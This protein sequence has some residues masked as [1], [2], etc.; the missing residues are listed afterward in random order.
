VLD[1]ISILALLISVASAVFVGMREGMKLMVEFRESEVTISRKKEIDQKLQGELNQILEDFNKSKAQKAEKYLAIEWLGR[2]SYLVRTFSEELLD[3]I[4]S[5]TKSML[6]WFI[7]AI[8][9]LAGAII[10]GILYF[11][12]QSDLAIILIL[13]T[14]F[15]MIP[16]IAF[17]RTFKTLIQIKIFR[18]SFRKLFENPNLKYCHDLYEDLRIKKLLK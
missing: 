4:S 9:S 18:D 17:Y 1:P 13:S 6:R 2:Y 5:R 10:I 15:A 8:T 3:N 12:T 14:Y 11:P 7:I 16:I